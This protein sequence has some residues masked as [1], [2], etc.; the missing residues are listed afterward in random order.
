M[1]DIAGLLTP[2]SDTIRINQNALHGRHG[3]K[4]LKV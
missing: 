4:Q 3:Y 1:K 2:V